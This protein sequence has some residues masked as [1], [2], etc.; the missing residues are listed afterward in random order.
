[1]SKTKRKQ[2][3]QKLLLVGLLLTAVILKHQQEAPVKAQWIFY[4]NAP[5][6]KR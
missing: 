5:P 4:E 6:E 3:R 1:M 2:L